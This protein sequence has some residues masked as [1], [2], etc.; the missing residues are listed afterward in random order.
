MT[1]FPK[2]LNFF[3]KVFITSAGSINMWGRSTPWTMV[4]QSRFKGYMLSKVGVFSFALTFMGWDVIQIWV[5]IKPSFE[6]KIKILVPQC[7]RLTKKLLTKSHYVSI[8]FRCID[9]CL[10]LFTFSQN[11]NLQKGIALF[12]IFIMVIHI[13]CPLNN[14][15]LQQ[16]LS[17]VLDHYCK[18]KW[19]LRRNISL[20]FSSC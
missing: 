9:G 19:H 14:N 10:L 11:K 15:N 16:L 6:V 7:I 8:Y 18:F 12:N 13:K 2:A 3:H 20:A 17:C 5:P 1:M 4:F